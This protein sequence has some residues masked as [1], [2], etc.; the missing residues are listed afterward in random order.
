MPGR[1][2]K[3]SLQR[4]QPLISGRK[5]KRKPSSANCRRVTE[6]IKRMYQVE[7]E[8]ERGHAVDSTDR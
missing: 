8:S 1:K 6:A 4:L 3:G 7:E 5:E 2:N